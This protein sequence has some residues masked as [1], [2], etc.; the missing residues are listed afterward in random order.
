MGRLR[1]RRRCQGVSM[2]RAFR[3]GANQD[4]HRR[5]RKAHR[6]GR[7]DLAG[8]SARHVDRPRPGRVTA[9]SEQVYPAACTNLGALLPGAALDH[10]PAGA[11]LCYDFL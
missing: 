9:A 6:R 4:D 2:R 1:L 3:L 7:P 11:A 8:P 10:M 5:S